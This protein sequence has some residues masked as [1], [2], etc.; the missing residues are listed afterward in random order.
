MKI[1]TGDTVKV[2]AGKDRGKTG[3][4]IQVFPRQEKVVVEGVNVLTRH[5]RG[6]GGRTGQKGQKISLPAPLHGSN[7]LLQCGKC[8]KPARAGYKV[9]DKIKTRVCKRCGATI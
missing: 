5:V 8:G 1:R 9:E 3:K 2:I 6:R 4:V 7:V